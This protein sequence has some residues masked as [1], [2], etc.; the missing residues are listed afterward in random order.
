ME[1]KGISTS[2]LIADFLLDSIFY[3]NRMSFSSVWMETSEADRALL[4]L[5]FLVVN[6]YCSKKS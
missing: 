5:C 4:V 3:R 6:F 2:F 1:I